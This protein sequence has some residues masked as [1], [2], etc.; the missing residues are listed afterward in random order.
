MKQR[1]NTRART[2]QRRPEGAKGR[3]FAAI[4]GCALLSIGS[5]AAEAANKS[6]VSV[7]QHGKPVA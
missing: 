7:Y 4:I 2:Q 3:F 5:G 6:K 1:I